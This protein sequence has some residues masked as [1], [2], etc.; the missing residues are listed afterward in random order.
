MKATEGKR[1]KELEQENA[2]LKRLLD[3]AELD[4]A[5][6]KELDEGNFLARRDDA[7]SC[8]F[9]RID[10]GFLSAVPAGSLARTATPSAGR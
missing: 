1:L 9:C 10:S 7:E 8:V 5:T 2:R 3:D 6:L 4:K